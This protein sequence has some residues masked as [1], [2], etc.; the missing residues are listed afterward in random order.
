ML[1]SETTSQAVVLVV[2]DEP[3]TVEYIASLLREAGYSQILTASN[4]QEVLNR[5]ALAAPDIALVDWHLKGVE[6]KEVVRTLRAR[7]ST[8]VLP[9]IVLT[10]DLALEIKLEAFRSGAT[11]F[12]H[13]P[14]Q[15]TEFLLR[16]RNLLEMRWLHQQLAE[17]KLQIERLLQHREREL[18]LARLEI[19]ERLACAAEYRDDLTGEHIVRVGRLSE[20][21]GRV[22]G[23]SEEVLFLLR[24]AAPLHDLGKIAIPDAILR[25]PRKLTHEER[26]I[27]RQHTLIG[28]QIL[29]GCPYPAVEMARQIALTHHERWDGRGYPCRLKG[30][31][32]PLW[33]RIVA[34]ADAYDAMTH[35]RPYRPAKSFEEAVEEIRTQRGKQFDPIVVDAFLEPATFAV[36]QGSGSVATSGEA[37]P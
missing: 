20:T 28:A 3:L 30:T 12:L 31:E 10:A 4:L 15:A 37:T 5:L 23:L 36:I 26:R 24:H 2:D 9:I 21:I 29:E 7:Y 34:L 1:I 13:K 18:E 11:E 19:L 22:L 16:V 27:M 6:G 14:F 32:I 17:Q 33:G 25:K 35:D 8:E